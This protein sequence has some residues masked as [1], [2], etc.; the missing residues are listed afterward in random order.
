MTGGGDEL[1][2]LFH[3]LPPPI[4]RVVVERNRQGYLSQV[5]RFVWCGLV[6]R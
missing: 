1:L 6:Q 4:L 2:E 5:P 3:R